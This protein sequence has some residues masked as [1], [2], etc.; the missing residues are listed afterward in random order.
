MPKIDG[1]LASVDSSHLPVRRVEDGAQRFFVRKM[2]TRAYPLLQLIVDVR[3]DE[4]GERVTMTLPRITAEVALELA[5][6]LIESAT[7]KAVTREQLTG[8]AEG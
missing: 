8:E 3:A 4:E 2:G 6:A 1:P 5:Q 7:G